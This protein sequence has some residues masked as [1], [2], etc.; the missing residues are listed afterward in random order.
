MGSVRDFRCV[1]IDA[2]LQWRE[3][4]ENAPRC[5]Y[6]GAFLFTDLS[7][8][9]LFHRFQVKE[10]VESGAVPESFVDVLVVVV[11]P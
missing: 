6:R 7:A 2:S 8:G 4:Y 3:R 11:R 10:D 9:R 1:L 5:G